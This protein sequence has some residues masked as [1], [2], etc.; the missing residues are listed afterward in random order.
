MLRRAL[1][2]CMWD[3]YD[4]LGRLLLGNLLLFLG[5]LP[6]TLAMWTLL[7]AASGNPAIWA[8]TAVFCI[9]VPV[10]AYVALWMSAML[11]FG[12][13]NS[14]EKDPRFVA[15]MQGVRQSGGRVLVLAVPF[16]LVLATLWAN[17]WFYTSGT[18]LPPDAAF[19]G[20]MAAAFCGWVSLLLVAAAQ[21]AF[22][23][24]V[25]ERLPMKEVWRRA[26]ILTL[27]YPG[28]T[29]GLLFIHA[30]V[31]TT[32]VALQLAGPLLFTFALSAMLI[33]SLHD[34]IVD[35]EA[36]AARQSDDA[37]PASWH[38]VR[39]QEFAAEETRLRRAR[40]ERTFRDILKPWEG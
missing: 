38:A 2:Q 31:W 5:A 33:N 26:V 16:F 6:L 40:Y 27:K 35:H 19:V 36:Q 15:F 13:L 3:C 10:A 32:G 22:P 25:R 21:H 29:F 8:L 17:A 20:Y 28:A 12:A 18:I 11:S 37:G 9:S 24:A 34:V 7:L 39:Q 4:C 23:I 1:H 14:A 30:F